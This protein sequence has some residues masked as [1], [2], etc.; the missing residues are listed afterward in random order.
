MDLGGVHLRVIVVVFAF[1]GR[2]RL[3][4]T[5]TGRHFGKS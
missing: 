3:G 1:P 2:R 4:R 5:A